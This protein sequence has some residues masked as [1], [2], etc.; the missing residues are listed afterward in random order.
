MARAVAGFLMMLVT[1]AAAPANAD[2]ETQSRTATKHVFAVAWQ[3]GFCETQPDRRECRNQQQDRFDAS[4]F[5]LHGLW[6]Q[7][8]RRSPQ[9]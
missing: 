2:A 4:H 8:A 7:G 3:P 1:L 6:P 5:A 9:W